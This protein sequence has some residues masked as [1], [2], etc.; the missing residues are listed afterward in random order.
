M[1]TLLY[2]VPRQSTLA[3]QCWIQSLLLYGIRCWAIRLEQ[4]DKAT[5]LSEKLGIQRVDNET[6]TLH[7]NR[8]I[9]SFKHLLLYFTCIYFIFFHIFALFSLISDQF[10][11][12][13]L[14]FTEINSMYSWS[15]LKCA[16]K[17]SYT[18]TD[19]GIH[20]KIIL[21]VT[22]LLSDIVLLLVLKTK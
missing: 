2:G 5:S 14:A 4:L 20:T 6:I 16:P 1:Y 9:E 11:H 7:S 22:L 12:Y 10:I 18:T 19:K 13:Y 8:Y 17:I 3:W 21:S 15:G